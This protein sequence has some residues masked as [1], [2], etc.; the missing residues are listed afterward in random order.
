MAYRSNR[1]PTKAAMAKNNR[2]YQDTGVPNSNSENED[3]EDMSNET[4]MELPDGTEISIEEPE[5]EDEQVEEPISE[6]DLANIIKAEIDDAQEY[7]DDIISPQRALAGQ[8][9]KGEPFGNEEEG[10]SQ[11]ISMD[12]RDTVQAMMPSIMRVFF[13]AN[14]VV[15]FAPNGP[16]DV[17]NAAQATEYVNYCLTRDN[18]L[19][20]ECHSTFKD[21]LIRKNGIMKVWWNNDKDI[22]THYFTG[23]DEA[24]FSVL[25][26]DSTVEVKDVEITYGEAPMMPPEMEGM[27]DPMG[28]PLPPPPPAPAT[29]DCTVVR[30]VEK[31][32]LCVQSVPPEE[33]LID[34]RARSIETAE[35]VAHRRYVTVSD[36][37]KMGYDFDE[38]QD[39]GYE[40]Q[41]DFGGNEEA[42]D[43][44][45]QAFTN[46]TGRT[47]TSSRKVLYIEGYVYVDMDGD[48]IAEL[49][50]VCV[51]GSAN[52]VLHWE[53]C[54]FIPFV[55]FCPD[56]EPHT[57]FG[58]SMADVTMDIQLIKSNILRNTLD[59][60][61]Q[62]IHPRTG[63]VEG[64][65]NIEDV[66]NT[67][68]GGIIRMRAPGM[69]QPFTIPF[70]GQQAFPMLQYMDELRENRT[71]I[72]KAAAG[73]D[74]NALQSSTRAAVA[75][76]IS[77]AAQHIELICR[78]FAE[79]GMKNLFR[80]SMQLIA[81][82]QDAP[83]MVRL[84]N[85]FV[86]IDPRAWDA[87]MDV[88]VN[89]A[90]GVG[91][92]EEK[93]AFLGQ[94][95]QKQEMLMQMGG[96]LAD[97]QG[98]YNTLAQMM[99]LAGYKDPTVFFN[100]PA[101]MP[102]PPP[103]A[104]PQPTPEEML[105]QVQMEAIRADI[106]KKAAEL[107]LQREDMLRKDDRERDKLDADLM[108]KAAE[109]E[110]KYGTP[111]NTASIEAMIQ[112]DREMVRQQEEMQR[113]AMQAQQAAQ[114]QQAQAVQQAVQ[115][116][117]MQPEMPMQ[118]E[119]PPEGMV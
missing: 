116:A 46:I 115:Q 48:G 2:M 59:S 102:P 60:L 33:F 79:T 106:Q 30:T 119:L 56:P 15:E 58:M 94:V 83:R 53:P 62:S 104:P 52:K 34:R 41:D 17:E 31:G 3:G 63:V 77:A 112:R 76:T 95:A 26:S 21:A 55:D 92:N 4:S 18:N 20:N 54:D 32:R 97:M 111:V 88:I 101:T 29:Y 93:M 66:M 91:S 42:F 45:P 80:K 11:A 38:V 35:F 27:V 78:I 113:A 75:A 51:A 109:I 99:A 24:T 8:Y 10:R 44:N 74:A 117:Q 98:Y 107:E 9:Y 73:L 7:I 110:A 86:P 96:P 1:K 89:V 61:A 39:L 82:N 22:T 67:E 68:V 37:V 50:R 103:P 28:M 108:I 71:G 23:L 100:D 70:V 87:N 64:Q 69:V 25:Q 14:N 118:P 81:K 19:F 105:S 84:R 90:I 43:R 49:C 13:A 47:D 36:L 72:S 57:F 40:T 65:V 85:K 5:M 6:K 114:A 12:V 16:E